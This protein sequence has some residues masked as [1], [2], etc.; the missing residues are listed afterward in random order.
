MRVFQDRYRGADGQTRI[1]K[2]WSVELTDHQGTLRQIATGQ[3]DRKTAEAIGRNLER[4]VR[5]R[6]SGEPLDGVTS[7]WLEGVSPKLRTTL[8]KFGLLDAARMA[9]MRPLSEHVLG[10]ADTPG[11][12]QYLASKGNV[13][14]HVERHP[15]VVLRA[16]NGSGAVYWSDISA[17]RLMTWLNEQRIGKPDAKSKVKRRG[18][19]AGTFNGFVTA[20]KAFGKWMQ[21]EGRVSDTPMESLRKLNAKTDK[22]HQRR[23][24]DIDELRWLLDTTRRSPKRAG[25]TGPERA[26]LY[27][28]AVETGLRS[29]ELASLTRS[30]FRLD[31][32]VPTVTVQA[33]YSKRRRDDVLPLRPNTAADLR[34]FFANKPPL[35][36]AFNMPLHYDVA[37]AIFRPDLNA[38]RQ[39]WINDAPTPSEREQ[40][41]ASSTLCYLDD[42]GRYA[43]FHAL[44]HTTGTLLAAGGVN[45]KTAQTLM[46][47]CDIN[48]TMSLYTHTLAGQ[49]AAAIATLP[50]FNTE[51]T[52]QQPN[53]PTNAADINAAPV[54]GTSDTMATGTN[55]ATTATN[56]APASSDKAPETTNATAATDNTPTPTDAAPAKADAENSPQNSPPPCQP[57]G[58]CSDE[59][60]QSTVLNKNSKKDE[61][62]VKS[63]LF[64]VESDMATS[65]A[66]TRSTFFEIRNK[67]QTPKRKISNTDG[68]AMCQGVGRRRLEFGIFCFGICFGFRMWRLGVLLPT[69]PDLILQGNVQFSQCFRPFLS[70]C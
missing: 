10:T 6:V 56:D 9:A 46:R 63:E 66:E 43:D 17:T 31:A 53:P 14:V 44:R 48:L 16:L 19:S 47:H 49:E 50:N 58:A 8:E 27:R 26:M 52:K 57:L 5:C 24:L 59:S 2:C 42:Q 45:P 37:R 54:T 22:R 13:A 25:M 3:R 60:R 55:D 35:A 69:S 61:N 40:R 34:D 62:I 70:F 36:K 67:S 28:L 68:D 65:G 21:R 20:L 7:K 33:S 39:A 29:S 51:P 11:W 18:I 23:P 32:A 30:S 64:P 41:E 12:K 1:V 4:L 38:A 15:K